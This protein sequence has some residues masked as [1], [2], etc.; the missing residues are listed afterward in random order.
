MSCERPKPLDSKP[1]PKMFVMR[2]GSH[3]PKPAETSYTMGGN[4]ILK[5]KALQQES[6]VPEFR[7]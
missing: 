7:V 6:T 3:Q 5:T 2:P 1:R 4:P